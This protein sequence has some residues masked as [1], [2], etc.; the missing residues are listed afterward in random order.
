MSE[1][2]WSEINKDSPV[3]LYYQI[4]ES[5]QEALDEG[6]FKVGESIPSEMELC[7][8]FEVSR[9]TVR[10]AISELV[11]DGALRKEKG[12]GTFVANKK[13]NYGSM[14]DIVT[15]YDK[16]IQRGY[17]PQTDILEKNL[18]K[19]SKKLSEKLQ[20]KLHEEV[21][22]I[23]RLRK[24]DQE[25]IVIITNHIPYKL[26]PKLMEIDL[27]DK[28]L[29]R[30]IAENCG[31]KLQRSEVVFYPGLADKIEAELLHQQ[32]GDPLQVINTVSIAQDGVLFDYFESKFRGNYGKIYS[33]VEN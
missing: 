8:I 15:Y 29:Y 30:V 3:P 28:S 26:C 5:I 2:L 12:K 17:D 20:L 10:Q 31:Y 11:S 32:K 7:S 14:Q 18:I 9:P 27:K 24:I 25:P 23:K 21:I 1:H 22:K 4:K 13:F 33:I 19:A 6:I 16:L